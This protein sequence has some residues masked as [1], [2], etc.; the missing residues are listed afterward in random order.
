MKTGMIATANRM[1][2]A[3]SKALDSQKTLDQLESLLGGL[4]RLLPPRIPNTEA[5]QVILSIEDITD[6][7]GTAETF[8]ST[9]TSNLQLAG[10]TS[11][12]ESSILQKAISFWNLNT[13]LEED[14]NNRIRNFMHQ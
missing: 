7:M 4:Y 12:L 2:W 9:E 5:S 3:S 6:D 14:L 10:P 8:S 11:I 13:E 1:V